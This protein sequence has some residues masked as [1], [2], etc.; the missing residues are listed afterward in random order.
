MSLKK[1]LN[2]ETPVDNYYC[3][4]CGQ[5]TSVER[6]TQKGILKNF[7]ARIIGIDFDFIRTFN[8]LLKRPGKFI[9]DYLTGKRQH[10]ISPLKYFFVVM[11]LNMAVTFIIDKPALEPVV[12]SSDMNPF[13]LKQL[14]TITS[15]LVIAFILLPFSLGLRWLSVPKFN[16]I[17]QVSSL[18]YIASQSILYFVLIQL[19][20]YPFRGT[21]IG[22]SE[23]IVWMALFFLLFFWAFITIYHKDKM[24]IL[25]YFLIILCG[26]ILLLAIFISLRL[27]IIA[28]V[29]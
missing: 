24:R 14:V 8:A 18:L 29:A 21:L 28:L 10:F 20:S 3:P 19:I 26:V 12:I 27:L 9:E 16:W 7:F 5:P 4:K 6:F 25:R 13:L 2:C 22:A 23:F 15:N 11:T 1:C 17:E